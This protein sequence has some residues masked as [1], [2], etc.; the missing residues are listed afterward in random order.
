MYHSHRHLSI[1]VYQKRH[2]VM[3]TYIPRMNVQNDYSRLF[4]KCYNP[5]RTRIPIK[6]YSGHSTR[7]DFLEEPERSPPLALRAL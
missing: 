4:T 2:T 7:L 3:I 1:G 5:F 6:R